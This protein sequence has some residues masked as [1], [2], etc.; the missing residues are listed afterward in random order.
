MV[1]SFQ[2]ESPALPYLWKKQKE[3][4]IGDDAGDS[5]GW[6][7]ALSADARTLVVGA[8]GVYQ[9]DKKR[10][11]VEVY[12][13]HDVMELGRTIHG[14]AVGDLFGYSIDIAADG[15]ILAIGSPGNWEK[16]D[17]PGYVRVY[18]QESS[19]DLGSS[20]KRLGQDITGEVIGDEFGRFV[21]LSDD[22][23]T[24]AV[25]QEGRVQIYQFE[26]DSTS[27]KQLGQDIDGEELSLSGDGKMVAIGAPW[28]SE[29]G[30]YSGCVK[31]YRIDSEMLRWEQ[32]GQT[33]YGE[34]TFD[35]IGWF[36]DISAGGRP[37]YVRVYHLEI[38]D[39]LGFIWKTH[40]QDI[41][42]GTI[43]DQYG[44]SG[45]LSNDGNTVAVGA[46]YSGDEK[47]HVGIYRMDNS[48]LAWTR[49]GEVVRDDAAYSR[50]TSLSLS[51]DGNTVVIGSYG[52]DG[53]G[54]DSGQVRIFT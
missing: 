24:L 6:A 38:G 5:L 41:T 35:L 26:G 32:Q 37:G 12:Y 39:D 10:G 14:L 43:G 42:G 9:D 29:N 15:K 45:S 27:W 20:W 40:G 28:N 49:Q 30:K 51:E 22:G 48:S 52:N 31:V 13:R 16:N 8:P 46:Y 23:K 11:Y 25:G 44:F 50:Q 36:V 4:L 47:G 19:D 21:S 33:I 7:V 3:T 18:H 2:S 54:T 34:A 1:L 17:R 53:N